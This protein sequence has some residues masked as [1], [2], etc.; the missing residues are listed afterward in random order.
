[1]VTLT[2]ILALIIMATEALNRQVNFAAAV[3]LEST[4]CNVPLSAD[5]P[6]IAVGEWDPLTG[7]EIGVDGFD[8]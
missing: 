6:D 4:Y 7:G 1:M 2:K 5:I 8:L 3:H